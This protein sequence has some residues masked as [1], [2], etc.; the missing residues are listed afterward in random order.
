M[1]EKNVKNEIIA[2]PLIVDVGKLIDDS[3]L[4]KVSLATIILCGF[5]MMM[6]GYD[7]GIMSVTAPAIMEEWG[8]SATLFGGVFSAAYVG[9][10]FG[11][12]ICGTIADK[13]GRKKV[14]IFS[15]IIFSL[16][17]LLVYFSHSV[18]ELILMRIFAGFGFGGA[19]PVAITLTSEYAPLKGKGKY[20]SVMYTGFV[21]GTT[22]A[23]YVASF[24]ISSTAGWRACF[25]IGFF[26]PLIVIAFMIPYMSESARW[27]SVSWKTAEQ[28]ENLVKL[29]NKINPDLKIDADTQFSS[30]GIT[31]QKQHSAK[32]LFAGRLRWVTPVMW[33]FYLI[34]SI[35]LFFFNSWGPQLIVLKGYSVATAA[36][37]N[38]NAQFVGVLSVLGAGFL[39][40][41]IGLRRGWIV[42]TLAAIVVCFLGGVEGGMFIGVFILGLFLINCAHMA[43]TILAPSIYPPNIRN[44][45]AGT[46]IGV[47]RIGAI[48]GPLLGGILLATQLKMS[49]LIIL[50]VA[51]PM[52]I[53]AVLCYI[54]GKQYDMYF[55]PLYGGQYKTE[56]N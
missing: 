23:G 22:L 9:F 46:G 50:M 28:R 25:L 32:E 33:A 5:I 18:P 1:S 12:I 10:L 52:F 29:I 53:V 56:K 4:N 7:M 3:K 54:V 39:Y 48:I 49:I 47:A 8:V 19:V 36:M 41:K 30:V 2:K 31:N 21:L 40:D 16:G 55:A 20:L 11:A 24:I 38:G 13:I 35:A 42:Y 37:I 34:S 27:L 26:A 6:D 45:G 15:G 17:T 44:Q 51:I 43:I 14:L